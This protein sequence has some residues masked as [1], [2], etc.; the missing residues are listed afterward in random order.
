MELTNVCALKSFLT[1]TLSSLWITCAQIH[2]FYYYNIIRKGWHYSE[3][4]LY[5]SFKGLQCVVK[6]CIWI[7]SFRLSKCFLQSFSRPSEI[8]LCYTYNA[9]STSAAFPSSTHKGSDCANG[10]PLAADTLMW[11][12]VLLC[13]KLDTVRQGRGKKNQPYSMKK[14][15]HSVQSKGR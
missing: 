4:T 11:S 8:L 7:P 12:S 3:Y 15:E 6:L 10:M 1:H 9:L 13:V 14:T 5:M 2:M